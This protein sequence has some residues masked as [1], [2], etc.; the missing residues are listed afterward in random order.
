MALQ[1]GK[2]ISAELRR[3][4]VL[5]LKVAGVSERRIAK[6]L[7][8]SHTQAYRDVKRVLGDLAKQHQEVANGLR[9]VMMLRYERL[10]ESWWPRALDGDDKATDLCL[11]IMAAERQICGLDPKEPLIADNRAEVVEIGIL[12]LARAATAYID[13]SVSAGSDG[14]QEEL[15]ASSR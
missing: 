12:E 3:Y 13:G 7:G 2:G 15:G 9:T 8:V 4:E 6:Q 14:H 10:L 1:N 11:K 5:R